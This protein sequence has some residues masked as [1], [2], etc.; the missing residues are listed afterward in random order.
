VPLLLPL[1]FWRCACLD[2]LCMRCINTSMDND[3]Q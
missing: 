3:N 1:L 2:W